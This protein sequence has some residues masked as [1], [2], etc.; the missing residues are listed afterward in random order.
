MRSKLFMIWA[1]TRW[2][3]LMFLIAPGLE[4]PLVAHSSEPTKPL[5]V[6]M[7]LASWY[8][9]RFEGRKTANGEIYD[10]EALCHLAPW[11]VLSTLGPDVTSLSESMTA[12]RT[13]TAAKWTF[14][15]ARLGSLELITGALPGFGLS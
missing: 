3:L 2:L 1:A 9:P 13:R 11:F 6:W 10:S 7:G 5:K 14:P 12:A 4:A 8:G 15:W